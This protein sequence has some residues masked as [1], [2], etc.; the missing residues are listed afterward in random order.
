M[1]REKVISLLNS[2]FS[3]DRYYVNNP[4]LNVPMYKSE[5]VNQIWWYYLQ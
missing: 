3:K 1:F 5:F 2:M 4:N